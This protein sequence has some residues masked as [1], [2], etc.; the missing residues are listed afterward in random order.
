[1]P[2]VSLK[3]RASLLFLLCSWLIASRA[4]AELTL[5]WQAP[6]EC[7]QQ[8]DAAGAIARELGGHSAA[9]ELRADVTLERIDAGHWRAR[10]RLR[11]A[12]EAERDVTGDAC[13]ALAD[14]AA[15]LIADALRS[16]PPS[17]ASPERPWELALALRFDSGTL[18]HPAPGLGLRLS[19]ALAALR[20]A[21][22]P[23]V[24]LPNQLAL[25]AAVSGSAARF[26]S[27]QLAISACYAFVLDRVELGPCVE[28]VPGMFWARSRGF[29]SA[30]SVNGPT[31]SLEAGAA[32]S[33]QITSN[34]RVR[35]E[36]VAARPVWFPRFTL[37]PLGVLHQPDAVIA[38]AAA[39]F[40][41]RF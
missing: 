1:M 14:T 37:A 23:R 5:R 16:L 9:D 36:L 18:P 13:A 2:L 3:R 20:L 25:P 41:L 15:W 30:R 10:L 40:A 29:A 12:L 34:V 27:A 28:V 4:S 7:P 38:R 26:I 21:L 32:A 19:R 6:P 39:G 11:G 24:L 33:F 35:V 22:E 8:R 17:A 31:L